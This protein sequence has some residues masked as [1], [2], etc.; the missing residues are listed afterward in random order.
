MVFSKEY[1]AHWIERRE[2]DEEARRNDTIQWSKGKIVMN[3]HC[4]DYNNAPP[5]CYAKC[6]QGK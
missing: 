3:K 2:K 4:P 1:M 5:S 6:L